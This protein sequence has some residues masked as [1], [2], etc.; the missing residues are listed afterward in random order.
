MSLK[1]VVADSSTPLSPRLKVYKLVS[2]F[3]RPG[4]ADF[5]LGQSILLKGSRGVGKGTAV[6]SVASYLGMHVVDVSAIGI[7]A[8]PAQS[9]LF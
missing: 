9:P 8:S 7:L 2:A 5:G 4:A 1:N 6:L 3:L